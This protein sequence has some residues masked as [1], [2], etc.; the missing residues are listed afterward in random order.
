MPVPSTRS[1]KKIKTSKFRGVLH[2]VSTDSWCA[3]VRGQGFHRRYQ[4]EME[5]V[6]H[7]NAVAKKTW[8]TRVNPESGSPIWGTIINSPWRGRPDPAIHNVNGVPVIWTGRHTFTQVDEKTYIDC[9]D[10]PWF[11]R[12]NEVMTVVR[13]QKVGTVKDFRWEFDYCSLKEIVWKF[14][15]G[16]GAPASAI[17]HVNYDPLDNRIN[18]LKLN[19][20]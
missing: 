10:Y 2:D 13:A 9:K 11:I 15:K 16:D 20:A 3:R 7:Y 17:E 5:A 6:A 18:N 8:P 1:K 19:G 12:D 14:F 4:T